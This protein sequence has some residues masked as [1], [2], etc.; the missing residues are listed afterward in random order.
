MK[1]EEQLKQSMQDMHLSVEAKNRILSNVLAET[2]DTKP[3]KRPFYCSPVFRRVAGACAAVIVVLGIVF[4]VTVMRNGGLSEKDSSA[5]KGTSE[6][7]LAVDAQNTDSVY[8]F[9]ISPQ[10][11]IEYDG[12]PDITYN[13]P[14]I[15]DSNS[16]L[17][18]PNGKSDYKIIGWSVSPEDRPR[19]GENANNTTAYSV[20]LKEK[21]DRDSEDQYFQKLL[22]LAALERELKEKLSGKTVYVLSFEKNGDR[23]DATILVT[24]EEAVQYG[25]VGMEDVPSSGTRY[26]V[27]LRKNE[28]SQMLEIDTMEEISD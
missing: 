2:A 13:S 28:T 24:G 3:K 19:E 25:Y 1:A 21:E 27:V 18:A 14:D 12:T 23:Y 11:W 4:A 9:S 26:H 10:D 6:N 7:M 16:E 22:T 5:P 20:W 15:K 8:V 17:A